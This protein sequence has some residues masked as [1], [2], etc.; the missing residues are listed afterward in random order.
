MIISLT[1]HNLIPKV[2]VNIYK[3]T[4]SLFHGHSN[5][6]GDLE[7]NCT[8]EPSED[9]IVRIG[10]RRSDSMTFNELVEWIRN[11][12]GGLNERSVKN[13]ESM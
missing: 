9:V 4:E 7:I 6:N 11:Y 1:L 10:R 8:C 13:T 3:G 12:G 5:E 2:P